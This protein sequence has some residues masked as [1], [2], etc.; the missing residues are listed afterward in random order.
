MVQ[1]LPPDQ[2]NLGAAHSYTGNVYKTLLQIR[3]L[4]TID[5][6]QQVS[7][8]V[9]LLLRIFEVS[10]LELIPRKIEF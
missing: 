6:Y 2:Y 5:A 10:L 7:Q 8:Q 4:Q 1:V 9:L 3:S